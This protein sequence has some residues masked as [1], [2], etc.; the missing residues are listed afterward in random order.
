MQIHLSNGRSVKINID[1]A[2]VERKGNLG[3]AGLSFLTDFF[4][5]LKGT[6]IDTQE[7]V[8]LYSERNLYNKIAGTYSTYFELLG[9][10]G[11]SATLFGDPGVDITLNEIDPLCRQVLRDNFPNATL[12]SQDM[13]KL[14][15]DKNYDFIFLDYNNH[16]LMKAIT[17]YDGTSRRAFT[18]ANKYVIISDCSTFYL[19]K[20]ERSYKRYSELLGK[21]I[22]TKDEFWPAYAEFFADMYPGWRLTDVE[23]T[24]VSTHMLFRRE[25][26]Q[27]VPCVNFNTVEMMRKD[28]VL[29]LTL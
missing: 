20:G 13:F 6:T 7:M 5:H 21:T 26:N 25:P 22:K 18:H 24:W 4:S 19:N 23:N 2:Q 16:T 9:G 8:R 3:D 17:T 29:S 12:L 14:E 28:P 1:P 10:G 15:Y 11:V 27:T